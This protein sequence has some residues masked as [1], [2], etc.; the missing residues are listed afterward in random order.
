M[1]EIPE[2]YVKR[3]AAYCERRNMTKETTLSYITDIRTKLVYA[4]ARQTIRLNNTY[5]KI[6]AVDLFIDEL[7]RC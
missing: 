1:N 7:T 2:E 6:K 4:E 5:E 3:I